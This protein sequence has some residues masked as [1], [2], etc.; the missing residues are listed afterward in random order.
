MQKSEEK[1]SLFLFF[2]VG[3]YDLSPRLLWV[4]GE[5]ASG[6]L[7]VSERAA[8]RSV[9]IAVRTK[10]GLCERYIRISSVFSSGKYIIRK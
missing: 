2:G 7:P 1:S 8:R 3:K 10:E 4:G 9:I 5:R 6:I